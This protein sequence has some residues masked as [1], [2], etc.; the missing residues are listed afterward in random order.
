MIGRCGTC[1]RVYLPNGTL[2]RSPTFSDGSIENAP[3][4]DNSYNDALVALRAAS[5]VPQEVH[6][7]LLAGAAPSTANVLGV[8]ARFSAS[9]PKAFGWRFQSGERERGCRI[10][11][12]TQGCATT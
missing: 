11:C 8:V 12:C 3:D 7:A 4:Y 6:N 5:A 10:P 2:R 9:L 1:V